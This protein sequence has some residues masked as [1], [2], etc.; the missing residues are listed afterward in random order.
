VC[1]NPFFAV[2]Q[3]MERMN[4]KLL[5]VAADADARSARFLA[6]L[7]NLE[8]K[9]CILMKTVAAWMFVR[10]LPQ[11]GWSLARDVVAGGHFFLR[12]VAEMRVV[13]LRR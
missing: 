12:H 13:H 9:H 2:K 1:S 4:A 8:F 7:G 5:H 6:F 3:N 10:R 11:D